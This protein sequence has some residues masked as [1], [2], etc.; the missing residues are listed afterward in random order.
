MENKA[1]IVAI[2]PAR[3]G[4]KGIPRK[5]VKL[6]NGKP[7]I[8]YP[9]ELAAEAERRGI[10][11][12][13]I[14]STE[15]TEIAS[16]AKENGGKVPFLRPRELAADDF[17]VIDTIIHGIN[18]WE[19]YHKNTIHSVLILQPTN[20]LT[21]IQDIDGA[22]GYYLHNQPE[23]KCLISICDAQHVRI[24]SLYYKKGKYLQQVSK[25]TDPAARRQAVRKLY[26]RNGAIYIV[27]RDF[28]LNKR[29]LIDKTPIYYEMPRLR[30]LAIDDAFDWTLAEFL[31]NH[32]KNKSLDDIR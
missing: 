3:G 14:V 24:P 4:S 5:N 8:Y 15:D 17:P 25:E 18:W 28:L 6:L 2:I 11:I 16:T 30:S 7:L 26:W 13:H 22:V 27:R 1:N 23:A 31:I 9:I 10:I 19:E 20:P 29:V 21:S 32:E 12:D